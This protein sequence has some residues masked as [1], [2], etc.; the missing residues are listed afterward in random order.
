MIEL[1]SFKKNKLFLIGLVMMAVVILCCVFSEVVA[2]HGVTEGSLGDR[3]KPPSKEHI[4]GT[5]PLG[6][7][8]YSRV[9]HGAQLTLRSGLMVILISA[10]IGV[11]LGILAG[12]RGG[13]VDTL[14]MRFTDLLLAFP[15][16][17]LAMLVV[18]ILGLSLQ[19]A[20]LAVAISYIGPLARLTRGTTIKVKG[21]EFVEAAR[22]VGGG[23]WHTTIT[24]IL[25]N[26]ISPIMIQ[27]SLNF[28]TAIVDIAGLSFLGLGAQPP[29][30]EWGAMLSS[31]RHYVRSSWWIVSFPGLAIMYIVL[32]CVFVGDG[33]REILDP[34]HE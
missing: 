19:N 27:L 2:T 33:L 1:R 21:L 4:F 26:I 15:A 6:R 22:A 8:V 29:M 30:P 34:K 18:S 31:G 11:P 10:L 17:L 20:V 16:F 24:H 5:D 7:D 23:G 28:G 9:V 13:V 12:Y 3:L 14:L 32:A 25:P